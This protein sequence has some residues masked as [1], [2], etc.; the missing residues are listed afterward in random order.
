MNFVIMKIIILYNVYNNKNFQ[1][2]K[3]VKHEFTIKLFKDID[4]LKHINKIL[5]QPFLENMNF[6]RKLFV[7][8]IKPNILKQ[9]SVIETLSMIWN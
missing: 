5:L 6:T 4:I 1:K 2:K 7:A 8:K 3:Y 9:L